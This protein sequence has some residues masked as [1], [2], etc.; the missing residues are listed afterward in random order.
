MV[1]PIL[2]CAKAS[3]IDADNISCSGYYPVAMTGMSG[4][5][6]RRAGCGRAPS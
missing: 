3:F 2:F 1:P 5:D 4:I 6:E